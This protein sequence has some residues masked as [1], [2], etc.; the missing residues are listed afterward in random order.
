MTRKGHLKIRLIEPPPPGINILSYGFYPRLGLPMIGAALEAAGH[1]VLIYCPQAAPIDQAD[2][3]SAD[4]VGVSTTTSTAPAAYRLADGLRAAGIPVVIGGP[5]PTFVPDDALPHADFVARGEGGDGLMQELIEALA[6]QRELESIRGLSFWRDGR[7]VHNELREPCED[8]DSLPAPNLSLIVG[9]QR[10]RETPIMTS[11]GCPF[12]C[13]FCTVTLMFGRR[14]RC[15]SPEN[16]VAELEAKRPRA[17]FFYDDNF[18]AKKRRLKVLLRMMIE[19]DLTMDWTAQVRTDVARDEELLELMRRSG[20]QRLALG[21]ESIDQATLDGYAKSQTVD[22]IVHSIDAL[23]R[24][25]I[26]CHGMFVIGADSDTARTARET[27]RFAERHGID[28]LMLNVLTPGLGTRQYQ[29]MDAGKRIFETRWQ[30]YDGQH[31]IYVPKNMT[32]IELQTEVVNGYRHF[33]SLRRALRHLARLRLDNLVD[34]LWGW[35][36]IRRWQREP[37]NR[38]YMNRL[39]TG[40]WQESLPAKTLVGTTAPATG[41]GTYLRRDSPDSESVAP[42]GYG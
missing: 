13:T 15:R 4:L 10:I 39:A 21:F 18:A 34:H 31:V 14:Y 16:V 7:P 12:D 35:L 42:A 9:A 41:E 19:R 38:A 23:H 33:Y 6:L 20:C 1:D 25:K 24:N 5:H 11:L 40:S 8:L 36:F 37:A 29:M 27:A 3:A 30:F 32:P 2:L 26:K 28:S 17:V 22:D